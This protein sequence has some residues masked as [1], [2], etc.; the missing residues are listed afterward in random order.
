MPEDIRDLLCSHYVLISCE[1]TCEQVLID[2]LLSAGKL[3]IPKENLVTDPNQGTPY[4]RLRKAKDIRDA[5]LGLDYQMGNNSELVLARIVD[6][7]PGRFS[8]PSLY[9]DRV[10]VRDFVT[11]P[12]IEM[13]MILR[14]GAFQRWSNYRAR[15]KQLLPSEFCSRELGYR[16]L[17]SE[18]F[19]RGYWND[20]DEI[21][22]CIREYH[23]CVGKHKHGQLELAD[24]LA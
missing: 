15:G 23:S 6:V 16:G 21:V 9:K 13:L 1:G 3:A 7:N 5:F 24:L 12:E 10:I 2:T 20:P 17:K 19:L 18:R 8:L 14:E 4:T 22:N 11:Q